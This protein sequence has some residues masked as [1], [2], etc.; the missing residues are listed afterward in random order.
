MALKVYKPTTPGRRSKASVVSP[1]DITK[2]KPEKKL[3]V[4]KKKT[5]GRSKGK[6]TVRHKGGGAKQRY[7]V[8]DWQMDLWDTP[9]QVLAIEYD[10]NRNARIA[11]V[12][13]L[14]HQRRYIVAATVLKVGD[15]IVFSKNKIELKIHYHLNPIILPPP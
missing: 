15:E 7:R 1:S 14:D 3:T 8:I 4:H 6:I 12:E 10:P 9:L 11:L 13:A 5:A 2:R